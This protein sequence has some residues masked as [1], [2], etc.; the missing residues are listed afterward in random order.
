MEKYME[1][2]GNNSND[3]CIWKY[4][5]SILS[6]QNY[7]KLLNVWLHFFWFKLKTL[8]GSNQNPLILCRKPGNICDL[9]KGSAG[10]RSMNS[11]LVE[12]TYIKGLME[13]FAQNNR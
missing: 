1:T 4:S 7:I 9:R 6:Q 8:H 5:K 12:M 3:I 10:F 13:A 2:Y 11:L